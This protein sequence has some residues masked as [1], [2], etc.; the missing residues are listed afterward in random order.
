VHSDFD[1]G[2]ESAKD[3]GRSF[4]AAIVRTTSSVKAPPTAATPMMAVGR[5]AFTASTRLRAGA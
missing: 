5:N 1:V 2:L 3:I 4:C